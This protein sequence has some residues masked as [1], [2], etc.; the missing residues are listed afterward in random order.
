MNLITAIT[1]NRLVINMLKSGKTDAK[2]W[3]LPHLSNKKLWEEDST[4]C[5]CGITL[6]NCLIHRSELVNHIEEK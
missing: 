2:N 4:V 1:T 5:Y 3:C 6:E